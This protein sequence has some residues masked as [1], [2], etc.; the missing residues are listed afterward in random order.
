QGLPADQPAKVIREDPNR[1]GFLVVGTET[2][3]F[4]STDDGAKWNPLK[5]NF[6]TVPVYDIKF[7]KK[8]HDLVVATHGRGLFVIDNITPLEEM[9]RQVAALQLFNTLPATHWLMWNKRGFSMGGYTAP[10]P[11]RGASIDYYLPAEIKATP[12]QM[13]KRETA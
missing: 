7:V 1:K 3:L 6:P 4:Y 12:E 9:N 10:N 11:P 2:G 8:S 13:K 5:S